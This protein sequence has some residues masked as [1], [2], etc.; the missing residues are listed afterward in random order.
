MDI[1]R[2][3]RE[4]EEEEGHVTK[5]QCW[6]DAVTRQGTPRIASNSRSKEEVRGMLYQS[7]LRC[8]AFT[9]ISDL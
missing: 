3:K 2:Q 5:R 8:R 4:T 7:L 6:S 1:E 9:L